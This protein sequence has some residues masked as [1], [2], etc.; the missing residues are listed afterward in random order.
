MT[1]E[2]GKKL[3][4]FFEKMNYERKYQVKNEEDGVTFFGPDDYDQID[5]SA[6][7]VLTGNRKRK[8]QQSSSVTAKKRPSCRSGRSVSRK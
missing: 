5:K 4:I 8:N 2:D 7:S 3:D 6:A 1:V